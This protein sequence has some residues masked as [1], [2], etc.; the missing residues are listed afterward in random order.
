M[1][2]CRT[3]GKVAMRSCLRRRRRSGVIRAVQAIAVAMLGTLP[4]SGTA[5]PTLPAEL[6]ALVA[7][8]PADSLPNRLRRYEAQHARSPEAAE[9][10]L[11]LGQLQYA[12]GEY[13]RAAD[14][15]A[16]AA[17]RLDPTRKPEARYWAGL[18]WLGL[19]EADPTRAALEEVASGSSSRRPLALLAVAQAWDLARRPDRAAEILAQ[20]LAAD[21]GEAGPAALERIAALAEREGQENRARQAR[22]RLLADYP[23]SIEAATARLAIFTPE[24]AHPTGDARPG[25]M[26]VV[27]GS[28]VDPARARSLATAA[29]AAGFPDA[30]VVS[31]G[32]GLAA[33]HTVRLG[34]YP[35]LAEARRAGEQAAQALGVA[36]EMTRPR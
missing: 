2:G 27:I 24:L 22:E 33:V 20:L 6:K 4:A 14:T 34:V 3:M 32:E 18:S 23:R 7:K 26:A 21:A 8:T 25:A 1:L 17:A 36:Y 9:A 10:A 29:R 35:R 30:R 11:L 16:R 15:F 31:R 12:R 5:A 19:G 13:R 28:F